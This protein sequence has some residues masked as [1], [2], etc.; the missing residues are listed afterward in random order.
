[1]TT[2]PKVPKPGY[3]VEAIPTGHRLAIKDEN[4]FEITEHDLLVLMANNI[5][6]LKRKLIG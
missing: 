6:E 1:M 2:E 5:T 3:S 4:G